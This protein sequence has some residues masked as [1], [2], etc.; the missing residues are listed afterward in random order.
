MSASFAVVPSSPFAVSAPLG[1]VCPV[2]VARSAFRAGR[3]VGVCLRPSSRAVSGVVLV[4]SFVSP[5]RAGAF[6]LRWSRRVGLA[7]AVRAAG[8][9]FSVSVPVAVSL[10]SPAP[11]L[12]PVRGVRSLSGVAA[13]LSAAVAF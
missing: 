8:G 12:A 5:S 6:A 3:C 2:V 10:V 11:V 7:V 9:V 13:A 4:A 1:A